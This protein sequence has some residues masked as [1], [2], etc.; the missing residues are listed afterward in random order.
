MSSK[1]RAKNAKNPSPPK[2]SESAKKPLD[3]GVI[4][5][6]VIAALLLGIFG[7]YALFNALSPQESPRLTQE[8]KPEKPK[9]QPIAKPTTKSDSQGEPTRKLERLIDKNL[10]LLEELA[11]SKPVVADE[12]LSRLQTPREATPSP[13]P[14]EVTPP[15]RDSQAKTS[16]TIPLKSKES[17]S[18]DSQAKTRESPP[19]KG[20]SRP[21]TPPA[22]PD[23]QAL[24]KPTPPSLF[25]ESPRHPTKPK[26]AIIIDDVGFAAQAKE[27]KRLPFKVT[28]SIFP[29]ARFNPQSHHL[30]REFP[31]F[32]VHLPLEA[33][34]F[35]QKEHEWLLAS[36]TK[37]RMRRKIRAIK[38]DFPRLQYLNNH[39]GSLFT[40]SRP[41][42]ERFLE[43][44]EEEGI[45]FIDSRTT[46][47]TKAPEI[48]AQKGRFLLSRDVFLDHERSIAYVRS[49]LQEAVKIAKERGYAVAIGHPHAETLRVLRESEGLK[50]EVEFVYVNELP[51]P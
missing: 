36:D 32:M 44:L 21:K 2:P 49:Q 26:L 24:A 37:E 3:K 19:S 35:Y 40:A 51:L 29:P 43:V 10:A 5:A 42:M 18:R 41:A 34:N 11:T 4:L 9:P 31:F 45:T 28:P 12:K 1:K 14:S 23:S 17:P 50:K 22:K 46:P 48:F 16:E 13:A 15:K 25:K 38:R 6:I 27:I 47:Q 7:G 30:A 33:H 8:S 20:D 39:T